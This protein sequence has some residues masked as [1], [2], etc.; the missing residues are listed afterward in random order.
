MA[1]KFSA[2]NLPKS[3]TVDIAALEKERNA[4]YISK[5]NP[6]RLKEVI[7]IIDYFNWG[8]Q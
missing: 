8:I 4:L 6:E 1:K 2:A 5:E 7:K 3:R